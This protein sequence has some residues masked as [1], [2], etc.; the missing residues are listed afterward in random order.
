MLNN[1]FVFL[2]QWSET[3]ISSEWIPPA[4]LT[5]QTLPIFL[6]RESAFY[7]FCF[8]TFRGRAHGASGQNISTGKQGVKKFRSG[9]VPADCGGS[10]K[11][12]V[13]FEFSY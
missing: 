12:F 10:D 1:N 2:K 9:R 11:Q 8:S 5:E 7:S 3:P 6:S 13:L 4:P